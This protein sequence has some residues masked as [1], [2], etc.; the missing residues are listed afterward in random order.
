MFDPNET[1]ARKFIQKGFW[2]YLFTFLI[3][4]LGYIIKI[5]LARDISQE[6]FGLFYWILSLIALLGAIND[7]GCTESLNYFLPKYLIH[8]E[9]GKA[10]YL[11]RLVLLI[12]LFTSISILLFIFVFAENI[13][14]WQFHSP[15]AVEILKIIAFFFLGQNLLHLS[16]SLFSATQDT[17][18]Q[19]WVDFIRMISTVILTISLFFL[20][21]WT[22]KYYTYAWVIGL[23]IALIISGFLAYR[24]YYVPYFRNIPIK[25]D[26]ALRKSFLIYA[27]PTFLSANVATILSQIDSQLVT[28]I[29]GNEAQWLY[30]NYL[31]I[32]GIPF[33][34]IT[35]II[36]F[37]FPVVAELFTKKDIGKLGFL[38]EKFTQ[39]FIIIAL[40]VSVFLFQQGTALAVFLFWELYEE[41]GIILQFSS[42]F[43]I[44]NFLNQIN[45]QFLSG[46]GKAWS[47]TI[48]FLVTLPINI[49]LNIIFINKHGVEWSALAVGLS[50]IPLYIMSSYYT[51]EFQ[52]IPSLKP[53][54]KNIIALIFTAGIVF[55]GHEY[56]IQSEWI[57]LI[58]FAGI[59][60][61]V[62]FMLV[63]RSLFAEC[64]KL[65][66]NNRK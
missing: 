8:K 45:F 3:A 13:A 28:K 6:D 15:H 5:I 41:S 30:T 11:L 46:T 43:L 65:I 33:L 52:K 22:L 55:L 49:I 7:F 44:F 17:K 27:F 38:H 20:D 60:N 9:Y 66:K 42:F 31:S 14:L 10:K 25:K 18:L 63:N 21:I 62:I 58:S 34:L 32:I 64:I 1:L 23:F 51:R 59:T 35:P 57:L 12:Q 50:W 56:L 16:I 24:K 61:F 36:A 4:P 54:W 2:L 39:Y 37:L 26:I 53:I 48:I 29:L 40:W 47:R 19:K